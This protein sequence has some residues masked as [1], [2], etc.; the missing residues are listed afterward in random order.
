MRKLL[1]ATGFIA[2]ASLAD[3]MPAPLVTPISIL[4][5]IGIV[6]AAAAAL[7]KWVNNA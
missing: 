7:R 3:N 2:I 6:T 4:C 5:L 1:I